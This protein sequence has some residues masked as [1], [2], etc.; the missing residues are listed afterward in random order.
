ME[1]GEDAV[2]A[3]SGMAALFAAVAAV[4]SEGD[5]VAVARDIYGGTQSLFEKELARFGL[6]VRFVDVTVPDA[7]AP[8]LDSKTKILLVETASNPLMRVADV[9]ALAK[10]A[11][12][13]GVKLLVDNTFLS[14]VL[15]QP[16]LHGADAVVH[17]TTKYI[18]GHS[19]A[20]GGLLVSEK[21]W[22]SRARSFIQNGGA[23]LSP[24]EAWLTLRGAKTL[25]LRI[26]QHSRNAEAIALWL[27]QQ[28][29]VLKVHYPRL[30][31]HPQSALASALFPRGVGGMLSF[32]IEGGV[33]AAD[34]F[35][36]HVEFIVFAPSLAGVSTSLSHPGKTSHRSLSADALRELGI[37]QGT[38][39]LSVGVEDIEDIKN[40]LKRGLDAV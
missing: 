31:S 27:E 4:C 14:P 6:A 8:Q 38:I 16:L 36:R 24:F 39:R 34:R 28:P 12:S 35:I 18:N 1:G 2:V 30:A 19:D 3:A 7:V 40:D 15:F 13:R 26:A 5:R 22:V 33:E 23:M 20:T 11:H 9:P 21:G 29:K 25:P 37:T 17:S 10:A 32:D